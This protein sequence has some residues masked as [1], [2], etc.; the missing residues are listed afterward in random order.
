MMD[1]D[2][3]TPEEVKKSSAEKD[4][5]VFSSF[6]MHG[7]RPGRGEKAREGKKEERKLL[8]CYGGKQCT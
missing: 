6:S 5:L 8:S 1:S 2:Y 4:C 7:N 3:S